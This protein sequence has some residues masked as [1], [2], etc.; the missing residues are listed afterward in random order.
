MKIK[1]KKFRLVGYVN[2]N[3]SFRHPHF[4]DR[5]VVIVYDKKPFIIETKKCEIIVKELN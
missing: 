3:D 5:R 1:L 2:I 4:K